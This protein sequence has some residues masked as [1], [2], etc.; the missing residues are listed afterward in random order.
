MSLNQKIENVKTL[1]DMVNKNY[2]PVVFANSFGAEDMVLT[3]LIRRNFP[4]ISMFTL[5]TKRLPKET[6]K[7]MKEIE[8][9]YSIEIKTYFPEMKFFEGIE[10]KKLVKVWL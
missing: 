7:L 8:D 1:L 6:L 3:D 9:H 10:E 4:D 2:A 5:D